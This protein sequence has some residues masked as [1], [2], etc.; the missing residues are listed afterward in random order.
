MLHSN[1]LLENRQLTFYKQPPC[2]VLR[3]QIFLGL[4]LFLSFSKKKE[5]QAVEK[6]VLIQGTWKEI[7]VKSA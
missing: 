4:Y 1:E 7:D 5:V 6:N 3:S 2:I